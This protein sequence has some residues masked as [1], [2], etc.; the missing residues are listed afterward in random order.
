VR[1]GMR[2]RESG[3][4]NV[5]STSTSIP[6]PGFQECSA[7]TSQSCVLGR[8]LQSANSKEGLLQTRALKKD[9]GAFAPFLFFFSRGGQVTQVCSLPCSRSTI[10]CKTGV[11]TSVFPSNVIYIYTYIYIHIYIYSRNVVSNERVFRLLIFFL[12][13]GGAGIQGGWRRGVK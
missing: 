13:G 5:K 10:T 7:G 1:T 3:S 9:F 8:I 12:G 6:G 4:P 2:W 11:F